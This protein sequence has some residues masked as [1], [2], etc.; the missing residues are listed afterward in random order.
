MDIE[1][2]M[3]ME[4]TLAPRVLR[5][6]THPHTHTPCRGTAVD[7]AKV[8]SFARFTHFNDRCPKLLLIERYRNDSLEFQVRPYF[9]C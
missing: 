2:S 6:P 8:L 9:M 3:K 7:T 5:P 1:Q 4:L